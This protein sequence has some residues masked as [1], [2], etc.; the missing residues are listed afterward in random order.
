M[1]LWAGQKLFLLMHMLD[2]M[3]QFVKSQKVTLSAL[4]FCSK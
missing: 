4:K 2:T 1:I 3:E